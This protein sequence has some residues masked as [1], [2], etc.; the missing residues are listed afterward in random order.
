MWVTSLF[1][2]EH[3]RKLESWCYKSSTARTYEFQRE[4][5]EEE[6]KKMVAIIKEKSIMMKGNKNKH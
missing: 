1:V 2:S 4:I 3:L 6:E 5:K